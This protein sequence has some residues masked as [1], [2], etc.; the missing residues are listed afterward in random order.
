[1]TTLFNIYE[2][3]IE[4]ANNND[5]EINADYFAEYAFNAM[6]IALDEDQI[7][8]LTHFHSADQNSYDE[9]VAMKDIEIN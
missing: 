4:N 7:G 1:M 9:V 6:D 8:M 2:G 5:V 3:A